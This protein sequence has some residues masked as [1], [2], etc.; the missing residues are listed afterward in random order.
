MPVNDKILVA[1]YNNIRTKVVNV[2]GPGSGTSG[3]GQIISSSAV[4]VSNR[5]T[6]NDYALLR[7]DIINAYRHIFGSSPTLATPTSSNI[8]RYSTT[9]TPS[10]TDSPY[11]QYDQFAD[12]IINNRFTVHPSQLQ[13]VNKGSTSR[14]TWTDGYW[15]NQLTCVITVDFTNATQARYFFNSGGEIRITSSRSGGTVSSQNTAWT[16]LL[17]SA[18]TR[19][20]GAQLPTTGFSPLNG[21]NFYRLTNSYQTWYSISASSPYTNNVYRIS[22]RSNVANNSA[23]TASRVEFQVEWIDGY[24][25]PDIAFGRPDG[26]WVAPGDVVDGTITLSAS[27]IEATGVLVP[28]GTGNFVVQSPSLTFGTIIQSTNNSR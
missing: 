20:F 26:L 8:I 28:A 7:N 25:D 5:I 2:L 6:V 10:T 23:G 9:F 4:S 19:Q 12:Q 18:G 1:D 16:N 11:T 21:Q 13:L 24:S 14:S 22:A 3:Y 15:N 17:N 27:T